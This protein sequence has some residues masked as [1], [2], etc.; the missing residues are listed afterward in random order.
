MREIK[1]I[2]FLRFRVYS[3]KDK[4]FLNQRKYLDTEKSNLYEGLAF[5][6][7]AFPYFMYYE[8]YSKTK[9]TKLEVLDEDNFAI[10]LFTGLKDR[11]GHKI[12]EGDIVKFYDIR[13]TKPLIGKVCFSTERGRWVLFANV[14]HNRDLTAEKASKCEIIG[15]I[16]ENLELLKC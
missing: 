8:Q 11:R 5:I 13:Y 3:Y 1:F 2:D 6:D 4:K 16:H 12:F 14:G 15:N 10:D 9:E 7:N